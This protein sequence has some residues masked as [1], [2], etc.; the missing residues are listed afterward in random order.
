M[1]R[2]I[3]LLGAALAV[4][5][6]FS[7]DWGG[8]LDNTTSFAGH[9]SLKLEETAGGALWLSVPFASDN[10]ANFITQGSYKYH[11][12]AAEAGDDTNVNILDIDLLKLSVER[13]F[14]NANLTLAA[15]RFP[16]SDSTRMIY[17]QYSDGLYMKF[18]LPTVTF[19]IYGGYTGLLNAQNITII[20]PDKTSYNPDFT[21]SYVLA[22]KYI[23]FSL[24]I[25]F[26][27][28]F[29][30]QELSV[31]AWGFADVSDDAYNR[32]YATASLSGPLASNMYYSA[33]TA[34]GTE[35]FDTLTNLS[36]INLVYYPVSKVAVKAGGIYASGENG[37]LSAFMP[38]TKEI[39]DYA[40]D[41]P[42]FSGL[43]K[44]WLSASVN[45]KSKVL[46]ESGGACLFA[47]S[48]SNASYDGWQWNAEAVWNIFSD[49]QVAAEAYQFYGNNSDKNKTGITAK[50]VIVF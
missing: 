5:P 1:K 41:E 8:I 16:V 23:P 27:V 11:Y 44:A 35:K 14:K 46:L 13:A 45:I 21:L 25:D 31:Q 24:M 19:G 12:K 7:F 42:M 36:S 50:A 39:A 47:C 33:S 2:T 32:F 3:M 37:K 49:V 26:P 22:P 15:G 4:V 40:V 48:N 34:F 30:N 38:V 18:A 17:N 43:V 29:A 10:S 6:A 28:L 20:T 9:D